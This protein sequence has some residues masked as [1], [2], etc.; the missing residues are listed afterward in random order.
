MPAGDLSFPSLFRTWAPPANQMY[1]CTIVEAARATTAAPT[2]FKGIEFGDPIKQR[3]IDGGLGCNNPVRLVTV[4]ARSLYPDRSISCVVSLGTG[5]ANVIGMERPDAFQKLLPTDLIAVLKGI[6]TDCERISEQIA[7]DLGQSILYCRLNVDQGLQEVSLAEWDKLSNVQLHTVQ[8]LQKYDVGKRVNQLVEVLKCKLIIIPSRQFPFRQFTSRIGSAR[9]MAPAAL[10]TV[11]LSATERNAV[12][13]SWARS[14]SPCLPGTAIQTTFY[15]PSPFLDRP[16]LPHGFRE[17]DIDKNA[18]IRVKS[19]IQDFT[20][21]WANCHITTWEDTTLYSAIDDVFVIAPDNLQLLTGEHMRNLLVEP[22]D[23][24][25]VRVDF[26][27]PFTTPPRVVVFL[28]FIDLDKNHNWRLTSTA[29]DID[30]NG[31]TLTIGTWGDTILYAAQACWIAYPQDREH[32]FSASV[33][34]MDVRPWDWPQLQQHRAIA[35]DGVEFLKVPTV[36]FSIPQAP[37]S[38]HSTKTW[39]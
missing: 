13:N 3:Y 20:N 18:N 34:T 10:P 16:R 35:F 19:T 38:L 33:N 27:R 17:L 4:E 30:V 7:Q 24:A 32:I 26:E 5:V 12:H 23:P 21:T 8:Y 15:F 14:T 37:V 28:N 22:N 9:S 1:N 36:P 6:A 25:S 2:F 39:Q 29:T 31:F 11:E